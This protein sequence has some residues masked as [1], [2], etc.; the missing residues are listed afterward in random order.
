MFRV[1]NI[2]VIKKRLSTLVYSLLLAHFAL[3]AQAI[4]TDSA[5]DNRQQEDIGRIALDYLLTHPE[6]FD[7]IEKMRQNK[8]DAAEDKTLADQIKNRVLEH[9]KLV[10]NSGRAPYSGLPQ[11]KI[12]I[13]QFFDYQ[14]AACRNN[15][16]VIQQAIDNNISARIIFRDW[17]PTVT[18]QPN[19]NAETA[20]SIGLTIWQDKGVK[21]YL[22]YRQG[23]LSTEYNAQEFAV[24]NIVQGLKAA[25]AP[26]PTAAKMVAARKLLANN[27]KLASQLGVT[28]LPLLI[29]LP[30]F[31]ANQQNVSVLSGPITEKMLNDAVMLASK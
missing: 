27:A 25:S 18:R 30:S 31:S 28:K 2:N 8:I 21:S 6:F 9:V 11:S 14:C 4:V 23:A 15:S 5:F 26:V 24:E 29:V 20:A 22:Q 1:T 17:T 3:P 16:A 7:T 13:V 19:S 10:L 12:V